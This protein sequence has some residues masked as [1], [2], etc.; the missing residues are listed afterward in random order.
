MCFHRYKLY[1]HDSYF[2]NTTF[3]DFSEILIRFVLMNIMYCHISPIV[4]QSTD[5][6]T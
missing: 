2:K 1:K 4:S 5:I 6:L 3:D